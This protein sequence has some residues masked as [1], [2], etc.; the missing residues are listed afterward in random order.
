MSELLEAAKRATPEE[1]AEFAEMLEVAKRKAAA[2]KIPV[3]QQP[4][5]RNPADLNKYGMELT[6]EEKWDRDHP[7][8]RKPYGFRERKQTFGHDPQV[9]VWSQAE[10]DA[11]NKPIEEAWLAEKRKLFPDAQLPPNTDTGFRPSRFG[12]TTRRG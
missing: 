8:I 3:T 6:A 9:K 10:V 5:M 11:Y 2:A 4:C 1:L 12:K 7:L